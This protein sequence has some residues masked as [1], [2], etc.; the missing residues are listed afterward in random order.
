MAQSNKHTIASAQT[1][2]DMFT[3]PIPGDYTF[4]V[5]ET[6][7]LNGHGEHRTINALIRLADFVA[8]LNKE[9]YLTIKERHG[10]V[11]GMPDKTTGTY[12]DLATKIAQLTGVDLNDPTCQ[13]LIC[14]CTTICDCA[15][16]KNGLIS[17]ECPIHNTDPLP[18]PEC[19]QHG[20]P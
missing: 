6:A 9:G 2:M 15:D 13:G 3:P 11:P 5:I 8:Q 19:P 1:A 20:H 7:R 14:T 18:N 4:I 10:R 12:I 17:N 16:H